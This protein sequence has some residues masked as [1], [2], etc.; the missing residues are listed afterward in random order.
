MT[1]ADVRKFGA[2]EYDTRP[3]GSVRVRLCFPNPWDE[4]PPR[5][6][7]GDIEDDYGNVHA[8]TDEKA[9][10][11]LAQIRNAL[12]SGRSKRDAIAPWIRRIQDANKIEVRVRGWLDDFALLVNAGDRSPNTLRE[13]KRFAKH[14]F[15]WW[16]GRDIHSLSR[17]DVKEWH[18]HLATLEVMY[19]YS[20]ALLSATTRKRISDAF[21]AMLREH[22][23]DSDGAIFVPAF[24][25]IQTAPVAARLM[26]LDD[27]AKALEAIDY[28]WRGAFLVAASEC[29]RLSEFRAY[30]LDDFEAPDRLRLQY[31]IQGTGRNQRRVAH[32]KNRT[33]EWRDLWDKETIAWLKWRLEQATPESRLRGEVALFW[34]PPA[35][36]PAKR[37]NTD[38]IERVWRNGCKDAGVDYVPFQQATRHTTLSHLSKVLPERMLQAHSRHKDKRS[39]DHY[40]LATP[41]REAIVTAMT[42][43]GD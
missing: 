5:L 24:P 31:S 39:L 12:L 29:L 9:R 21:R 33:A 4:G 14:Y 25:V 18:A 17:R 28:A 2:I 27:R 38:P 40:T 3:N 32:N 13:Y 26:P 22:S 42:P 8:L 36:N 1:W 11:V 23:K 35:D 37:W 10:D 19:E 6:R 43:K 34:Y 16:H 7:F 30:E 41:E 20:D 15:G